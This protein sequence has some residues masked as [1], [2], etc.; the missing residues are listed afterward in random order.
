M[1]K[2]S[3]GK[4]KLEVFVIHTDE[5]AVIAGRRF[6]WWGRCKMVWCCTR[7]ESLKEIAQ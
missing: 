7:R 6:V 3:D 2:I 5:E 1:E 4:S